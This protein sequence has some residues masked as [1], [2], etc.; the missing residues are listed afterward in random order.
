MCCQPWHW[1]YQSGTLVRVSNAILDIIFI[2]GNP[3]RPV[4]ETDHCLQDRK[5]SSQHKGD[6]SEQLCIDWERPFLLNWIKTIPAKCDLL[7]KK[8]WTAS[9]YGPNYF[10]FPLIYRTPELRQCGEHKRRAKAGAKRQRWDTV[11]NKADNYS[12]WVSNINQRWQMKC[13]NTVLP[14]RTKWLAL[15]RK[16]A[17]ASFRCAACDLFQS[18]WQVRFL[19]RSNIHIEVCIIIHLDTVIISDFC[20]FPSHL[21]FRLFCQPAAPDAEP[22]CCL[23]KYLLSRSW[24]TA[25][26][27]WQF[28]W[29]F[30]K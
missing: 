11:Y 13:I 1:L 24:Q 22:C 29:R 27:R 12:S 6:H 23:F 4:K 26:I 25:K 14:S 17:H 3:S 2:I 19:K 10:C 20:L 18:K 16:K 21:F 30:Y 7:Q 5:V 8:H 28:P 9:S 15:S